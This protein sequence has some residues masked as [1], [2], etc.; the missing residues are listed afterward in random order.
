MITFIRN[1]PLVVPVPVF[2]EFYLPFLLYLSIVETQVIKSGE[3]DYITMQQC[4]EN[5][6][7]GML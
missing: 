3:N 2:L 6:Y 5:P 1:F 4:G 7:I